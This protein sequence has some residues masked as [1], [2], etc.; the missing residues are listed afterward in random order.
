MFNNKDTN[1]FILKTKIEH[2]R[3]ITTREEVHKFLLKKCLV[4]PPVSESL[5]MVSCRE[6]IMLLE[7]RLAGKERTGSSV[8]GIYSFVVVL[9]GSKSSLSPAISYPPLF[10]ISWSLL[11]LCGR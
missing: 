4:L 8:E 7:W 5:G 6:L 3:E 11:S 9:N 10:T 2:G 1:I